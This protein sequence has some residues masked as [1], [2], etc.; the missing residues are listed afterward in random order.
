MTLLPRTSLKSFVG[1]DRCMVDPRRG[2]WR[3]GVEIHRSIPWG[4]LFSGYGR[5]LCA[6]ACVALL[7]IDGLSQ[8]CRECRYCSSS[9]TPTTQ[10]NHPQTLGRWYCWQDRAQVLQ[11]FWMAG[12]TKRWETILVVAFLAGWLWE[13]NTWRRGDGT[14]GRGFKD[15]SQYSSIEVPG[16][17]SSS[18]CR[19]VLHTSIVQSLSSSSC[20][21]ASPSR[22][23]FLARRGKAR[24]RRCCPGRMWW[25]SVVICEM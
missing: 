22:A 8:V 15:V 12:H 20:A 2:V 11:S 23:R 19:T 14:Y 4:P 3:S 5:Y 10:S 25:M 24:R 21:A 9:N 16:I 17:I 7:S 13:S 6:S 18:S 1:A